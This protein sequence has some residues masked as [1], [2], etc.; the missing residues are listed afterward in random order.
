MIEMVTP[1]LDRRK[2][3]GKSAQKAIDSGGKSASERK[4]V[5]NRLTTLITQRLCKVRPSSMPLSSSIDS[6]AATKIIQHIM[7][8]AK[9]SKEK[10]YLTCCSSSLIFVFRLM[11]NTPELISLASTEY[12][13]VVR[14]W[15]TKRSSGASLV[16]DLIVHMPALAQASILGALSQAT[17]D[18]RVPVLKMEAYRLLSQLFSKKPN[19]DGASEMEKIALS[20]VNESQDDLLL[21]IKSTLKDEE[22]M[23]SKR[24]RG[25]FVAFE[26]VLPFLSSPVSQ[27]VLDLMAS[28]KSEIDRLGDK[29][30]GLSVIAT[31]IANQIDEKLETLKIVPATPTGSKSKPA[32]SSSN[33]KSKKKKKKR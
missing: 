9:I 22:L 33:K 13:N 21:T 16:E 11:P 12:G 28:I 23:T 27:K 8:E 5:L 20:N 30:S 26:K 1:L 4:K 24:A 7:K 15:S 17:Q 32:V 3:L 29:H 6:E 31:K 10:E 14:E 19:T 18:A 2:S 25:V